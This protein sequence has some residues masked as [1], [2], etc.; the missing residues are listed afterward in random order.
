[1]GDFK[2]NLDQ[3]KIAVLRGVVNEADVN[4]AFREL[5]DLHRIW[6]ETSGRFERKSRSDLESIQ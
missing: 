6:K 1:M 3:N 4:K 5:Q 2:H